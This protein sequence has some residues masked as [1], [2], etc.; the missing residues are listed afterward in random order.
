MTS[1]PPEAVPQGARRG[2]IGQSATSS[3][4]ALAAV[5]TGLLLDVAVS[6]HFGA[7]RQSDA[8]F[9]ASRIPIGVAALLMTVAVQAWVPQFVRDRRE[10]GSASLTAFAS[11]MFTAV[12]LVGLVVWGVAS[13]LARPLMELTAPGLTAA[14]LDLAASMVPAIFLV[15]PLV[16][17]AETVRGALNASYSFVLPAGMNVAMN[18]P[19]AAII[20]A[21]GGHDIRRVAWAYVIG[22][23]V[24]LL[25]ILA[26]AWGHGLRIHPSMKLGDPRVW[27]AMR[28]TGRPA[29]STGLNLANRTAEQAVASFLP[30]GS[31]TILS[32]AQ[33]LISALGG[34]T[35]FRPITVALL[36][37]LADA[38]H[39]G[40]TRR[41]VNVLYRAVRLIVVVA[42]G[43]T[44]FTV[45]LA[46]PAIH[47]V[48][49]RGNFT[50]GKIDL[51]ALTFAVYGFSLLGSGLQRV[52]LAPFYARL[53]TRTP[54]RN[55]FY[56][57]IVDLVLLY[58]C[59]AIFGVDNA[60]AVVGV[61]IAY[62]I[63]QYYIVWHAWFRLRQNLP[64]HVR[65]LA[66]FTARALVVTTVGTLVM[67]GL[68]WAFGVDGMRSRLLL[69]LVTGAIAL[70]GTAVLGVLGV[71]LAQPA[72]RTRVLRRLGRRPRPRPRHA[73]VPK[74]RR[75]SPTEHP[76]TSGTELTNHP[77]PGPLGSQ[78]L[79]DAHGGR[80]TE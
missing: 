13:L 1:R 25:A 11:R 48:F 17:G 76:T 60:Y 58:P 35:F 53:D 73:F 26:V 34:G 30:A 14:Q 41:V 50:E 46:G 10:H 12:L 52:L 43:L 31:I 32:Y 29:L 44:A 27:R 6:V 47:F 56:G 3:V 39:A 24:Q 19:A 59:M 18:V 54:L 68:T 62:G 49:H 16:A 63:S 80:P 20:L 5:L 57:V 22:A 51:L 45:A 4:A 37:R 8:F 2:F 70:V 71:A 75:P 64:L 23:G 40:D 79:S 38:E 74:R 65:A 7:G 66:G 55:T 21:S 33:R 61:A 28:F 69:F 15:V 36:P 72:M 78:P 67:L 42:L 77:L 9:A